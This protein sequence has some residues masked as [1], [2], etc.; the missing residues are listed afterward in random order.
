MGDG[1]ARFRM[2]IRGL[3]DKGFAGILELVGRGQ[4]N[5]AGWGQLAGGWR[6]YG[7][8]LEVWEGDKGLEL[9]GRGQ[10]NGAGWGKGTFSGRV[11]RVRVGIRSPG[12]ARFCGDLRTSG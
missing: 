2:G 12:D 9:V 1:V 3:G 7:W 10:K 8:V 5:G 4:K 11:A 6:G